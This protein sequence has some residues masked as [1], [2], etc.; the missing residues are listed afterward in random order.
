MEPPVQ[1]ARQAEFLP[2]L[3]QIEFDDHSHESPP[4]GTPI[5]SYAMLAFL[6]R[7][8]HASE[9]LKSGRKKGHTFRG[10]SRRT[11]ISRQ[12]SGR[13]E[14]SEH[15]LKPCHP[16]QLNRCDR[17]RTARRCAPCNACP[18]APRTPVRQAAA[19]AIQRPR[20]KVR[21]GGSSAF[22]EVLNNFTHR[23]HPHKHQG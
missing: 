4:R 7:G 15:G 3:R 12:V 5:K 1:S 13:D 19:L 23:I 20:G 14:S 10:E 21:V 17:S 8:F 11:H 18:F 6:S 9:G 16:F 2:I 22:V